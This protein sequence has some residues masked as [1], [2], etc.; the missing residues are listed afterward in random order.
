MYCKFDK[1]IDDLVKKMSLKEKIG[2]LNQISSPVTEDEIIICKEKIRNGQVGSLILAASATAGNDEQHA[3][4]TDLYNELQKVAIEESPNRIP[5]IYGRDVIHGH[6]TVYPLPLASASSFNPDLIE[7]CYRNIA[8]EASADSVHWTFSPMLDLCRDPRWGRIVEGP[9]EDPYIGTIFARATI[10]GFQGNDVSAEDSLMA[11]AK[12]FIGY[13]ASEGGRDYYRTEISDYSLYNYYLPAFKSAIDSGVG[14]IMTSF[15]DING[16]PITS[17]GKYLKEVLRDL[18]GFEGF[19]VSDWE[20]VLQLKKQGVAEDKKMCAELAIKAG[21][22]MDMVS[23]CYIDY[24]EDLVENG[25]ISEELINLAVKRILR[26]KFAKGL[27]DHPYC[28]KRCVDRTKHLADAK[29]LAVES[30]ILLKNNGILP[31]NKNSKVALIGPF[32]NEKRSHLGTW[33]LDFEINDVKSLLDS[34]QEKIGASNVVVGDENENLVII[35]NQSDVVVLALGEDW[36]M[37]GESRSK[38][39]IPLPAEQIELI[40]KIKATGK[41]TVGVFF[42]GRQIALQ[43]IADD[44]DAILYAWHSGSKATEAVCDI[45]FGDAVPSGKT[46]VTFP[47]TTG[48]IPLYYNTT[49]SGRAVN[50]YYGENILPSY[51]DCP[52]TPY[53]PFG[54]GLSYTKFSYSKPKSNAKEL[55]LIELKQGKKFSL[56]VDVTNIGKYNGKETIQLYLYDPVASMMRPLKEL[57]K[58]KKVFIETGKTETVDFLIGYNDIGFYNSNGDYIVEKGNI[59]VFI[60]ENCLTNNSIQLVIK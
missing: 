12:H 22:D 48:Q 53:Y 37:T 11:C 16:Q 49:S 2:Q 45:V 24:L 51:I 35:A 34:V 54:Y 30:I 27:F 29:E 7:K 25:I 39:D 38:S 17:S 20:S 58:F 13:G 44:F 1:Q 59:F 50:G 46:P 23:D 26:V 55:S 3:I 32:V 14:T 47:R 21:L 43:D 57:K 4:L 18:L 60:G 8:K 40:K 56:S 33:S 52:P 36:L 9:G 15:N 28:K 31:L 5:L 42:C 10:K 41:K 6:K 19:T